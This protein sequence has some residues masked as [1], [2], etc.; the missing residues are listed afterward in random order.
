MLYKRC[1]I[2]PFRQ[3]INPLNCKFGGRLRVT[4]AAGSGLQLKPLRVI[5]VF[6]HNFTALPALLRG[7]NAI[8]VHCQNEE[9]LARHPL[10]VTY[11]YDQVNDQ[12]RVMRRTW[13]FR[14][15]PGKTTQSIDTGKKHWPLMRELRLR[16][17]VSPH[18]PPAPPRP[19]EEINEFTDW[20]S[21]PYS[22]APQGVNY[23][24]DFERGDLDGWIGKL[25]TSPTRRGSDFAL[26]NILRRKD[27]TR[28]L[29]VYRNI[30]GLNRKTRV[31]F[32]VYL[33][34]VKSTGFMTQDRT[35]KDLNFDR[36]Q[37]KD[38]R[39]WYEKF[40]SNLRQ[41]QWN[42]LECGYDELKCPRYPDRPF[43]P[44][45]RFSGWYIT[46][47]AADVVANKDV[48]FLLDDFIC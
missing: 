21:Y 40:F 42:V 13:R 12:H 16:C 25:V 30:G 29:K 39:A 22:K 27:G 11:V 36:K 45:G 4:L 28:E 44:N 46:A 18:E 24:Q 38:R 19:A 31:H 2:S 10:D 17:L 43:P 20:G 48:V 33:K 3:R 35:D 47:F 9:I 26:D 8:T 23:H 5:G 15:L 6:H 32:A 7:K 37:G 34:G 41:G 1:Q 14:A